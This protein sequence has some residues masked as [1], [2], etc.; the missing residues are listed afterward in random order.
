M[1]TQSRM[2]TR[3][4]ARA[5]TCY[6]LTFDQFTD[7]D[8][9]VCKVFSLLQY[10]DLRQNSNYSS[11]F[12]PASQIYRVGLYLAVPGQTADQFVYLRLED[13]GES[14]VVPGVEFL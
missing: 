3:D 8:P 6:Q 4:E 13:G 12:P 2:E 14:L 5:I 11:Y 1:K 9:E 7:S 10:S